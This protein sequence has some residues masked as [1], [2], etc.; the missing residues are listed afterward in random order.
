M[1]NYFTLLLTLS[2]T[3][4]TGQVTSIWIGDTPG[5]RTDWHQPYNWS[6]Q[7][8]PDEFTDVIIPLDETQSNN[9]PVYA[10][11]SAE[12]NSLNIWPGAILHIKGGELIILDTGKNVYSPDQIKGSIRNGWKGN[13]LRALDEIAGTQRHKK[14]Y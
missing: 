7:R 11:G 9:Y 14:L 8:V 6:N 4:M 2:A 12:I 13:T 10:T 1:R 5:H 3:W